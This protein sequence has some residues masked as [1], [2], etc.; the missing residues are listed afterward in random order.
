M[1]RRSNHRLDRAGALLQLQARIDG[2]HLKSLPLGQRWKLR[3]RLGPGE[4]LERRELLKVV[5]VSL[6]K[7]R[8]E[9]STQRRRC[10]MAMTAPAINWRCLHRIG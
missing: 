6:R 4:R 10:K 9:R 5:A 2:T 7:I 3:G 1:L 8:S